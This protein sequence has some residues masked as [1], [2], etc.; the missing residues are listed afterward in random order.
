[1][2]IGV[3]SFIIIVALLILILI[4]MIKMISGNSTLE[5]MINISSVDNPKWHRN[6]CNYYV[7]QTVQDVLDEKKINNDDNNWTIYLPCG[8]D[9]IDDEI[10]QMPIKPNARYFIVSDA[11]NIVA[12]ESL[13][14]YVKDHHGYQRALDLMPNTYILSNN[15]DVERLKREHTANKLYIMKKNIQ[16][17]EGLHITNNI[18]DIMNNKNEGFVIAQELL[19]NPYTIAGR[20]INMRFYVLV[21]CHR[22]NMDV[23]VFNDGFMYY[24]KELFRKG[25]TEFG[26]NITT[27]YIDRAVYEVNPLTQQ[28][29]RQYL[30]K[31]RP[32]TNIEQHIKNQGLK[33][34]NVVFN[35]IYLLLKNVFMAYVGNICFGKLKNNI[36]FQLFGA[37]I[38]VNDDLYP[39]IMEVNKG[40]D[41]GAKDKRDSELKHSVVRDMLK[42]IG[43][44]NKDNIKNGFIKILDYE[45]T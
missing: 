43:V 13:W 9:E 34:S 38:A 40:P 17:Q 39:M 18:A 6:K 7:S 16:R 32:L 1:M 30:D 36:T 22:G 35:R 26:P 45:K 24:T 10:K 12:K 11:D 33:I 2:N 3:I 5:G 37:D 15:D 41:L 8:Y 23:Y 19:Q 29:F 20:K 27:G 4:N 21:I 42:L 31:D 28:D 14:K 25:S 44:V